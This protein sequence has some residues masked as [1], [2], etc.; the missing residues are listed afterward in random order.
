MNYQDI[1]KILKTLYLV[2]ESWNLKDFSETLVTLK[3]VAL[4]GF[5]NKIRI[6]SLL[7]KVKVSWTEL[8]PSFISVLYYIYL[9]LN[10]D[11]IT[12]IFIETL[13]LFI[14][15]R[16]SQ[17]STW[18]AQTEDKL[19]T[20]SNA[21]CLSISLILSCRLCTYSFIGCFVR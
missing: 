18:R 14:H 17:N 9:L 21:L 12:V 1:E 2:L 15:C 19:R 6:I 10:H 16:N 3:I 13:S 20:D 11:Y 5:E 8:K 7:N 4:S